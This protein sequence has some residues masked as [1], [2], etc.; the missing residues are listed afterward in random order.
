MNAETPLDLIRRTLARNRRIFNIVG[1]VLVVFGF[2]ILYG[3][4]SDKPDE[5]GAA[6]LMFG[7]FLGIGALM[8]WFAWAKC[9]PE[10]SPLLIAL[11]QHPSDVAWFYYQEV[12]VNGIKSPSCNVCVY[13]VGRKA[14]HAINVQNRKRDEFLLALRTIAPHATE[15]YSK[16][17]EAQF[18]KDPRARVT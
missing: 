17:R 13:T 16:E 9:S 15:G 3:S 1:A 10:R 6:W 2:L 12:F 18:K 14:P 7:L 5:P 11:E 8:I 4:L